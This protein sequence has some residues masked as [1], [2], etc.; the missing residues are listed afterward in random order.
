MCLTTKKNETMEKDEV[1][2]LIK[3][4]DEVIRKLDAVN[5]NLSSINLST[6]H[7]S[8]GGR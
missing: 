7:R 5:S 3:K 4:L 2:I 6:I 8:I 1:K